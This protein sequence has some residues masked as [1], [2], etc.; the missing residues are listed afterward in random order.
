MSLSVAVYAIKTE[1][2]K[3]YATGRKFSLILLMVNLINLNSVYYYILRNL[4]MIAF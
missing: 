4:S 2:Q 3:Q 1:R